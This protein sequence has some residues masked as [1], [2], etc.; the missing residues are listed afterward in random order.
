TIAFV[1][2]LF[3]VSASFRSG[4]I[5]IVVESHVIARKIVAKI[6]PMSTSVLIAFVVS[7]R[8]KLGTPLATASLPVSRTEPDGNAGR[9]SRSVSGA[10]PSGGNGFGGVTGVGGSPLTIRNRPKA[11]SPYI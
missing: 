11:T 4:C 3:T 7:G 2:M 5:P 10:V 6:V 9:T 8:R 1:I